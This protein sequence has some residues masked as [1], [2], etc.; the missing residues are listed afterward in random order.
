MLTEYQKARNAAG[1]SQEQAAA[2]ML[3]D[4]AKLSRIETG[5]QQPTDREVAAMAKLY[6]APQLCNTYCVECCEIGEALFRKVNAND[7]DRVS[8]QLL[9]VLG[10]TGKLQQEII[11][12]AA[13]GTVDGREQESFRRVVEQMDQLIDAALAI[14][15]WAMQHIQ[16]P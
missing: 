4:R 11:R 9:G 12:I 3:M 5:S 16:E 15:L 10:Q 6:R 14:K 2:A 13:D 7:L 1:L 8:L